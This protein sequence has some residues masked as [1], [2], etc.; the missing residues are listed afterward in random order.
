MA[1]DEAALISAGYGVEWI[2]RLTTFA[3]A[4]VSRDGAHVTLEWVFDSAYRFFPVETDEELGY[5]LHR[6]DAATNKLLALAGR[7]K[8]RDFV[9]AIHLDS[10]YVSLGALAWAAAGKDQGLNPYSI[11]EFANRFAHYRQDEIDELKL[12]VPLS[13]PDLKMR[14]LDAIGRARQLIEALPAEEVG[15]AYLDPMTRLPVTPVPEAEGFRELIRQQGSVG[16]A[17]PVIS[18]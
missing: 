7:R 17:W 14:W 18:G 15:C 11:I 8:A 9:D 4:R 6:F 5:R 3:R 13:L 1:V 10:D 12:V 2:M 16:G